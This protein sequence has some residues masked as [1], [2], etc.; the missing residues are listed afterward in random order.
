MKRIGLLLTATALIA[1]PWAAIAASP[2]L[3]L[4]T[5]W[6]VDYAKNACRG[7]SEP[8]CDDPVAAVQVFEAELLTQFAAQPSCKGIHV[9][10]FSDP[11]K[12]PNI[13]AS[14]DLSGGPSWSISLN[15]MAGAKTQDW[16]M[17]LGPDN[18]VVR[19]GHGTPIEIARNV[20]AIIKNQGADIAD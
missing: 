18:R 5:W 12:N 3:I 2:A 11:T 15:F 20:C 7:N 9:S 8:A 4:D 17:V 14:K 13:A 1:S 19:Q 16:A 10:K 6:D